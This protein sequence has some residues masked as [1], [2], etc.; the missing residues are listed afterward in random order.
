MELETP[1]SQ[2]IR[3]ADVNARYDAACK[4]LLSEKIILSWIMKE[5]LSEYRDID[6]KDIAAKYI[7]GNP[8]VGKAP[9][10]QDEPSPRIRGCNT[11]DTSINEGTIT[12]DIRFNATVPVSGDLI[13]LII[14]V[15][16]QDNFY[17]GYPLLKR[18][19]YYCGRLISAQYG[20][21]FTGSRYEKLKKVY[22]IWICMTPPGSRENSIT[23][24]SIREENLVGDVRENVENYDLISLVMICLGRARQEDDPNVLKLLDVLLSSE[25]GQQEKRHILQEEFDIPMTKQFD[26]EVSLMCNL[27][28]GVMEKGIETGRLNA[29]IDSV[30]A[31]MESAQ[32]SAERA[33]EMLKISDKD[34]ISLKKALNS[35]N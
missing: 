24:Y 31:L 34:K 1:I 20:T 19:I 10:H 23:R 18:G 21:E 16:A 13:S 29:L 8:Q 12:Y 4:R 27:S 25:T 32:V 2:I 15:E 3:G 9:V 7:E 17:P 26:E 35:K 14:N 11:E 5:V 30:H 22:S 6:V 28:K 33:M